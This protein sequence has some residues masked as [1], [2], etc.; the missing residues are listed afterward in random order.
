MPAHI[1]LTG[2]L[3]SYTGGQAEVDVEAGRTVREAIA[4]LGIP[5]AIVALVLVNDVQKPKDYVLQEGDI[6]RLIM[7]VGGGAETLRRRR[8]TELNTYGGGRYEG[9]S[10]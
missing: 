5:P 9:S 4:A 3:K 6:V 7:V 2:A 1:K 10:G 8:K